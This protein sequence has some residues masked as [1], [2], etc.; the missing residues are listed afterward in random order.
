MVETAGVV[1]ALALMKSSVTRARIID[2]AQDTESPTT[3]AL[4]FFAALPTGDIAAKLG[5][6]RQTQISPAE[7]A[8][9]L[10]MLPKQAS[11]RPTAAND[12]S[13][14]RSSPSSSTTTARPWRSK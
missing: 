5:I 12:V 13:S 7:R 6:L 14:P 1:L 2:S 9:A 10:A 4:K 11:S 3:F 8:R